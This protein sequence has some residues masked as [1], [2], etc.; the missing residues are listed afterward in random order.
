MYPTDNYFNFFRFLRFFKTFLNIYNNIYESPAITQTC[1]CIDLKSVYP[2]DNYFNFFRFLRFFKT[3]LNIYN[4]IYESPAITQTCQCIDLKDGWMLAQQRAT[5]RCRR[6]S[7]EQTIGAA[8]GSPQTPD[9][10]VPTPIRQV[11]RAAAIDAI[12]WLLWSC[13]LRRW[14]SRAVLFTWQYTSSKLNHFKIVFSAVFV[15]YSG[16]VGYIASY[17][18]NFQNWQNWK[19]LIPRSS[20]NTL[21]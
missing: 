19:L 20:F 16:S 7:V 6:P 18:V 11:L 14:L 21:I 9:H 15:F 13:L 2:T 1:Q 17:G 4:N 8:G 5:S 10:H 12:R 3:F